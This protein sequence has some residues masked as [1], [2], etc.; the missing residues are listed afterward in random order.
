MVNDDAKSAETVLEKLLSP[1]QVPDASWFAAASAALQRD[2][3]C[4]PAEML[5]EPA[6][7]G[8]CANLMRCL[9][10]GTFRTQSVVLELLANAIGHPSPVT[11]GKGA[12]GSA[13]PE[14]ASAAIPAALHLLASDESM[15]VLSAALALCHEQA[16]TSADKGA[17]AC[18]PCPP[19]DGAG[20]AD[21]W[22][23][24][25]EGRV[26]NA[27]ARTF[28]PQ[29]CCEDP[30][31]CEEPAVR[32][33]ALHLLAC[34]AVR[35]RAEDR[36]TEVGRKLRLLCTSHAILKDVL[37]AFR[38]NSAMVSA[39]AGEALSKVLLLK[40]PYDA[41][42]L[43]SLFVSKHLGTMGTLLADLACE[44][45]SQA[46]DLSGSALIS[47]FMGRV[48]SLRQEELP[49]DCCLQGNAVRVALALLLRSL[50]A[51]GAAGFLAARHLGLLPSLLV[52]L[53]SQNLELRNTISELLSHL[54]RY[55]GSGT[56]LLFAQAP[57]GTE[58]T[59][60]TKAGKRSRE[61]EEKFEGGELDMLRDPRDF[62]LRVD[63]IIKCL[64]STGDMPLVQLALIML[65]NSCRAEHD[66]GQGL[67]R[68]ETIECLTGKR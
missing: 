22:R 21:G 1:P 51:G 61:E 68:K 4:A 7:N 62:P 2:A 56:M 27:F 57:G 8:D 14:N 37:L 59:E 24:R 52:F 53:R 31:D 67:F 66:I 3:A 46:G 47:E 36:G 23:E 49:K 54:A 58:I 11:S 40:V 48:L 34:L 15:P 55:P 63:V 29:R 9:Q 6:K 26:A 12:G 13:E 33:R 18:T 28:V 16:R 45:C 19:H 60:L 17:D 42:R 44:A 30:T 20:V 43:V 10:E 65:S 39:A 38:V 32:E 50:V 35:A 5:T 64:L 25:R 41:W